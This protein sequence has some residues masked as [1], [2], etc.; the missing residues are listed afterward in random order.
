MDNP[1]TK[2]GRDSTPRY[3][4]DGKREGPYTEYEENGLVRRRA[5]FRNDLLH[6][7][8][9]DFTAD[10]ERNTNRSNTNME[11]PDTTITSSPIRPV[12]AAR[13]DFPTDDR[14]TKVRRCTKKKTR[15]KHGE[16]W[17]YYNKNGILV[18]TTNRVIRD[19]GKYFRINITI[20][21]HSMFLSNSIPKES[22]LHQRIRRESGMC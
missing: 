11:N 9:S 16:A 5:Y 1:I 19:Y 22:Q 10:G 15:Y 13:C 4:I 20:A 3:R 17:P 12:I 14:Y 6:G 18:N 2:S 21:N 8:C 7:V